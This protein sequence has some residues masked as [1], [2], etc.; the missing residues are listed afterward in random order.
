MTKLHIFDMN[1]TL[2]NINSNVSWKEFLVKQQLAPES[3]LRL[4]EEYNNDYNAGKLDCEKFAAFQFEEF[5]HKDKPAIAKLA[6]AHFEEYIKPAVRQTAFD[7]VKKLIRNGES[8]AMITTANAIVAAT[9]ALHFGITDFIASE[10]AMKWD[11]FTGEPAG[12]F[13][14]QYGKIFHIGRLCERYNICAADVAFY[15]D[16]INDI[17]LLETV[18]TPVAVNP[19]AALRE[20]AVSAAWQIMDWTV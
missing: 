15:A 13:P 4:A 9:V 2:L 18:G 14:A 1:G 20:H 6:V 3:A 8:V 5:A 10:P 17:P 12:T 19:D 11:T 16:S 7:Y